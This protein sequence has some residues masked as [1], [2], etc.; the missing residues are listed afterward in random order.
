MIFDATC[1][2]LKRIPL[3]LWSCGYT[4]REIKEIESDKL[5]SDLDAAFYLATMLRS[6]G[7]SAQVALVRTRNYGE[8]PDSIPAITAF[9]S[10]LVVLRDAN[11]LRWLDPSTDSA[12]F[13]SL[14]PSRQNCP[15]LIIDA[16]TSRLTRTPL[17]PSLASPSPPQS[18]P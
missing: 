3:S 6:A 5:A 16:N 7:L 11:G 8:W 12:S 4:P 1:A 13:W 14:R 15:A 9:N 17:V 18:H 2:R 10:A